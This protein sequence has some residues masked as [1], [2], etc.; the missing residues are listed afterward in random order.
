MLSVVIFIIYWLDQWR[1]LLGIDLARVAAM[2]NN[3]S[4]KHSDEVAVCFSEQHQTGEQP[5]DQSAGRLEPIAPPYQ[6]SLF[7]NASS[8]SHFRSENK[9]LAVKIALQE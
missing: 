9:S 6:H 7:L 4:I 1:S 5:N 2:I 8:T 3:R